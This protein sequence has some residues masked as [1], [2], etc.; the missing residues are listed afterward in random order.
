MEGKNVQLGTE[1]KN[2]ALWNMERYNS[3]EQIKV[4]VLWNVERLIHLSKQKRFW[5]CGTC[6]R[7]NSVEQ[8]KVLIC[9]RCKRTPQYSRKRYGSV[10]HGTSITRFEQKKVM[11]LRKVKR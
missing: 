8:R 7:Y 10:K 2:M 6:K 4:L 11:V 3:A 9:E 1:E 5:F